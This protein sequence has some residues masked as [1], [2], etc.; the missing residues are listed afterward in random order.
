[1]KLTLGQRRTAFT[2]TDLIVVIFIFGL[3]FWGIESLTASAGAKRRA[4]RVS[5]ANNLKE[6]GMAYHLWADDHGGHTPASESVSRGG[7]SELLSNADQGAI[8]WTNYA[9]M[10]KELGQTPKLLVCPSDKRKAAAD[11][12][13]D[14]KDNTHVSY[15]VGVNANDIYPQSIQGGDRNLGPGIK[16]DSDYGF[17]PKTGIG[18]DVIIPISGPVS[19]S[20]RIHSAGNTTGAGNIL[21]GDGSAQQ[22]S[23]GGFS[24]T[25]LHNAQ[26]DDNW[27]VGHVPA[28]P[29]IR[30]IFP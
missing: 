8:C 13:I 10:R 2:R 1:M 26:G 11:F 23:S 27:A 14:F 18:N 29:S 21:I 20:L 24:Q 3:F 16:P 6:I 19:W 30:L 17:S 7:W 15:F 28:T 25:W 5:C 4:Q 12:T 9:I 22:V